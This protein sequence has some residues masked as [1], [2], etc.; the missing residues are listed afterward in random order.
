MEPEQL[1]SPDARSA[2]IPGQPNGFRRLLQ[3]L[4]TVPNDNRRQAYLR[5]ALLHF[6]DIRDTTFSSLS[7]AHCTAI[8]TV[9]TTRGL[10]P[11]EVVAKVN[12]AKSRSAIECVIEAV[13]PVDA[14][15]LQKG[16]TDRHG[17][18]C[19]SASFVCFPPPRTLAHG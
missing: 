15:A 10:V 17:V 14:D 2:I 1:L 5:K 19:K 6:L 11:A 12:P 3:A 13:D 18:G 8:W 16:E 4:I 7:H 9:L